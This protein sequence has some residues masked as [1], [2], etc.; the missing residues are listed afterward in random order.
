MMKPRGLTSHLKSLGFQKSIQIRTLDGNKKC[1]PF[2]E[3]QLKR[4]FKRYGL[5]VTDVTVVTVI[6]VASD[7]PK[8][9]EVVVK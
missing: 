3:K 1:L 5:D 9:E 8:I 7:E 4:L 6:S 2:T